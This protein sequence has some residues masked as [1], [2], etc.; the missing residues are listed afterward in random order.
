MAQIPMTL[1]EVE[2]HFCS[3]DWQCASRGPSASAWVSCLFSEAPDDIGLL[4]LTVTAYFQIETDYASFR[5]TTST[6]LWFFLPHIAMSVSVCLS[7]CLSVSI[8]QKPQIKSSPNFI[9]TLLVATTRSSS[10]GAAMCYVLPVSWMTS[11]FQIMD[12][13]AACRYCSSL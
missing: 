2:G 10:G 5:A 13:M 3:Y 9:W 8:T 4:Y 6:F 12:Q 11:R 1:S 7:V